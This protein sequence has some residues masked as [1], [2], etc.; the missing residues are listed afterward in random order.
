MNEFALMCSTTAYDLESV[1]NVFV[2]GNFAT[3]FFQILTC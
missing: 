1:M 2:S 3:H